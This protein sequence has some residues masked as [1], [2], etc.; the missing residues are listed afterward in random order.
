MKNNAT[1]L[2]VATFDK[3]QSAI[4]KDIETGMAHGTVFG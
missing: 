2:S 1:Y 3:L 4:N